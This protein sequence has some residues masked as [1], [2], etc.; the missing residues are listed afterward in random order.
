MESV[1][2]LYRR[3]CELLDHG[4]HQAAIVPL[5][6]AR[7]LE[8]D[9][10][11]IREALGRALFHAQPLR[12]CRR[13]VRGGRRED[14]HER[15][16]AVLPRPLDAA[17]RT[18]PRGLPAARARVLAAPRAGGLQALPGP[19]AARRRAGCLGRSADAPRCYPR[20]T[21]FVPA[22]QAPAAVPKVGARPLFFVEDEFVS[23]LQADIEHRLAASEPEIEVLLAEVVGG[24]CLRVFIDHPD[25]VTL[26]M[27]ERVTQATS[28][29][30]ASATRS[31]SPRP[32]SERP[33]TKP[34][35]FRRFV[36]RRARVRSRHPRSLDPA[37]TAS[38]ARGAASRASSSAPSDEEVTLAADERRRSRS[39]TRRSAVPT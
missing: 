36:G 29:T 4:D 21:A 16:R 11:S 10:A 19:R 32:G 6:K 15:L 24:R 34:A 3:G 35:H 17:A 12:G 27:C 20:C 8:P 39:P 33:L 22:Q 18:P 38:R 30:C 5:S 23:T 14:P 26:E 13:G 37:D 28:T 1:Y 31:R 9:K 25:G 7:D 2:D